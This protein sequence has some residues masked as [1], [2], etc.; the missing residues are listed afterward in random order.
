MYLFLASR[1]ILVRTGLLHLL[2][3]V[4]Q[5]SAICI[6]GATSSLSSRR[7]SQLLSASHPTTLLEFEVESEHAD[8][9]QLRRWFAGLIAQKDA[10]ERVSLH[11]QLDRERAERVRAEA[12][13]DREKAERYRAVT[14]KKMLQQQIRMTSAMHSAGVVDGRS[15]LEYVLLTYGPKIKTTNTAAWNKVLQEYPDLVECL[16]Q[17]IPSWQI[18][19]K[20]PAATS[21]ALASKLAHVQN[22]LSNK[23]HTFVAG[24]GLTVYE[25]MP[26]KPT[27]SALVCLAAQFDV[28]CYF[29]PLLKVLE[30]ADTGMSEGG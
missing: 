2:R 28:P 11:A 15:F 12:E 4:A 30:A 14:E 29:Q 9:E 23:V 25:G 16:L 21:R 6:S 5:E 8:K 13:R 17:R 18:H 19:G 7:F 10:A 3:S 20:D 24:A 26:D 1:G 22:A 27:T